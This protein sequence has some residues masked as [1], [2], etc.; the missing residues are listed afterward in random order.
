MVALKRNENDLEKIEMMKKEYQKVQMTEE[1]LEKMKEKIALAKEEKEMKNCKHVMRKIAVVAAAVAI[2]V[3]LPNTSGKVAYAMSNIPVLGKLVEVVTFRDY[4]YESERNNADIKV[5]E[6]VAEEVEN[7]A[8]TEQSTTVDTNTQENL[9]KTTEEINAEIQKI[10]DEI[11]KEFEENLSFE[12]G[13]QDVVVK[14][15]VLN[16]TQ[17]YFT[18]KLIC[19]QGA[20]SGAQWNYFY[21]ID[22]TTGE[23]MALKD[24]F[25]EGADYITPI[26]ENIKTQMREQMKAD[27]AVCYWVDDEIEEMNFKAITDETSFY[28]NENGEIVIAF[29]E[30]EVAPG[31][32]GCVEFVIPDEVTADIRK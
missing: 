24:L 2:F 12:E 11:V 32:M 23:R 22:L 14:H 5:P 26:S 21:T 10:T 9:K 15:E 1:Q 6:L 4:E 31:S 8:E 28:L 17:D 20:G 16:S 30:Y 25:V 27:E 3:L 13:Y 19:Y 29:D 7:T 18:L